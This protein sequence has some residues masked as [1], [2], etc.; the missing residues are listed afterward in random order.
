VESLIEAPRLEV[1]GSLVDDK[2]A[3]VALTE[4][5]VPKRGKTGIAEFS[6]LTGTRK[7]LEMGLSPKPGID[8]M[9]MQ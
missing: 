4:S 8:P 2:G 9:A 3:E 5:A 6:A 7:V 1:G